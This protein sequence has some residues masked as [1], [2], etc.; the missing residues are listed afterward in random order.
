MKP[1]LIG[2]L[3]KFQKNGKINNFCFEEKSGNY[4]YSY[5]IFNEKEDTLS[6]YLGEIKKN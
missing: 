4:K 6:K 3:I 1:A 5:D 2:I